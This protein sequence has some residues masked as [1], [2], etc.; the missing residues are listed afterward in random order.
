M[1]ISCVIV[2][3]N[4]ADTT[5]EQLDRICGYSSLDSIIVVDNCS[6]DGSFQKLKEHVGGH[7]M[8]VRSKHNGGYGSGNNLG[9]RYAKEMLGATHVL[10]ANPDTV[11]TDECVEHMAKVMEEHRELG[12]IAPVMVN[13]SGEGVA[14]VS[15]AWPLRSWVHELLETGPVCRR[16]FRR[17][18]QYPKG[19]LEGRE[20][21]YVGAVPGSLLMV[22]ARKMMECGGYDEEVFLYGE[23]NILGWNM[24]SAGYKTALLV[25]E[26]YE[27]RHA[28]SISKSYKGIADRQKLRH[29]STMQYFQYYL[30]ISGLQTLM[31][32]V[33][34]GIVMAEI[35]FCH[36]VLKM[37][38]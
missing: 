35:W 31:T 1:K 11:F 37:N 17:L 25:S 38:W 22:D 29:K 21:A 30:G 23:E 4:D 28:V 12:A 34:F 2:N 7:I 3:Y 20:A 10:I 14:G 5:I 24:R 9:V 6:D 32:K 33:F 19:Y 36:N 8:L 13:G 15:P 26:T 16:L 18:L 27:H